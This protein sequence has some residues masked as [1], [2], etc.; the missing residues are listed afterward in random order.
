MD[1]VRNGKHVRPYNERLFSGGLRSRLHFA[2][3]H[4]IRGELERLGVKP[5]RVLELGCYDGRALDFIPSPQRYV[6]M[7]ANWEGGLD[8]ARV[9]RRM[10][11]YD[12][13]EVRCPSDIQ[14]R[15]SF[16]LALSLET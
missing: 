14:L 1:I 13:I 4:W 5:T 15:E 12:F 11:G 6:G 8:L 2:R 3:F 16:D 7:D 10:E 9:H